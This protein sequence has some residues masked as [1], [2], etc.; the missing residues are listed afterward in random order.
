MKMAIAEGLFRSHT[1]LKYRNIITKLFAD[2]KVTGNSQTEALLGYTKLNESRMNRLDKKLVVPEDLI[3]RLLA[4]KQKYVWLV[5]SEGW[6]GDSAQVV[7]VM[8][9]LATLSPNIELKLVFRD[10]NDALMNTFLTN[11]SRSIPKL[12]VLDA[13]TNE[14]KGTWG[15]RPKGAADFIKSY[16][17]QYGVI[18]ETA[19]TELHL[20][21]THDKGLSTQNEL[22]ELMEE[23]EVSLYAKR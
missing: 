23:M 13:E 4:L 18:D 8:N 17:S 3:K 6:C 16:K 9:K 19:K 21:Y 14:V 20:W 12:I 10:E 22:I 11:G 15:P 5:I 1:Y 7:P 2:G